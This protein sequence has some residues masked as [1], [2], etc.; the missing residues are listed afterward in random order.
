MPQFLKPALFAGAALLSSLAFVAG[1]GAW[2]SQTV[3]DPSG[4]VPPAM[5]D[6]APHAGLEAAVLSGGCFWGVQGI[7]EHVR[8]VR[9]V[10]A[11]YAGGG[12]ATAHYDM[13]STGQTGHAE[14]VK[15]TFDPSQISYGQILRI[16]FSVA[17]DPTQVGGQF[18]DEGSQYRSEVFYLDPKQGD[19]ARR[20][21]AQLNEAKVFRAPIA[22][23]VDRFSGF[24]PA[25][26][27]HQDYLVRHPESAYIAAYD[28]PKV[29]RLKALF[30]A[31]YRASPVLTL[32]SAG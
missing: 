21:I 6:E 29:A 4:P 7:F 3:P 18:P 5:V 11:G 1:Y 28:L 27:Y 15:I 26:A 31:Q 9:Q 8:G 19:V 14:S 24:F 10:V 16:F 30:G 20:Y 22:T 12:A 17:T 13:V 2:S 23:R 25:E 32:A